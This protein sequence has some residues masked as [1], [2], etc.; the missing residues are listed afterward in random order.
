MFT[1]CN[2]LSFTYI[3]FSDEN[4][5]TLN[6]Q[7]RCYKIK[8]QWFKELVTINFN[9]EVQAVC[10]VSVLLL[11]RIW[12]C[13]VSTHWTP[14]PSPPYCVQCN[15]V[16]MNCFPGRAWTP[17][18]MKSGPLRSSGPSWMKSLA[19]VLCRWKGFLLSWLFVFRGLYSS[20]LSCY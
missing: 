1:V 10:I 19:V 14:V 11:I 18:R 2:N 7:L 15:N 20:C 5:Y 12:S 16:V 17:V 13:F 3:T 4:V 6:L 9:I 8:H